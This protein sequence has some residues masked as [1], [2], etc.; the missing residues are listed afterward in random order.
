MPS[1]FD[2][3]YFSDRAAQERQMAQHSTDQGARDVHLQLAGMYA[4]KVSERQPDPPSW[5]NDA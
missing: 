1:T 2:E 3:D 5:A 4:A